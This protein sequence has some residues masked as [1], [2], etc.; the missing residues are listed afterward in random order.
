MYEKRNEKKILIII[1]S[2]ALKLGLKIVL[3][4]LLGI[5]YFNQATGITYF[6]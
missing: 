6:K 3:N 1:R 2:S 4:M 5:L